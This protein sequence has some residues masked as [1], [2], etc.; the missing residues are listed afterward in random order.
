MMWR[1]CLLLVKI[2]GKPG[3]LR[4]GPGEGG[5]TGRFGP[6]E[7]PGDPVLPTRLAVVGLWGGVGAAIAASVPDAAPARA[8]F[9]CKGVDELIESV[10]RYPKPSL[11]QSHC[12]QIPTPDGG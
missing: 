9:F 12:W 1:S 2:C 11:P 7:V 4:R 6:V 5:G 8:A 10:E 3:G